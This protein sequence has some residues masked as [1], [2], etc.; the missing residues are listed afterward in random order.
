MDT[1]KP[2]KPRDL[3]KMNRKIPNKNKSYVRRNQKK[4][5][6]PEKPKVVMQWW[7]LERDNESNEKEYIFAGS[8]IE[9]VELFADIFGSIPKSARKSKMYV[10]EVILDDPR[11]VLEIKGENVPHVRAII[12]SERPEIQKLV[13]DIRKRPFTPKEHLTDRPF[14]N[15]R[16]IINGK[17]QG[18]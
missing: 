16:D 13:T 17:E 10:H 18:K 5:N 3:P 1:P 11:N 2:T 7:T 6:I 14:A 8:E 12:R 15:L 4:Y 9:A